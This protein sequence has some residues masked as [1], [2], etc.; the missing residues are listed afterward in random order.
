MIDLGFTNASSTGEKTVFLPQTGALVLETGKFSQ[1]FFS[2][3]GNNN[4]KVENDSLQQAISRTY[5]YL[6]QDPTTSTEDWFPENQALRFIIDGLDN[7]SRQAYLQNIRDYAES[8][9]IDPDLVIACFLGEQ[10][11]IAQ[12]STRET[13]KET[14]LSATPTLFRS[15]NVSLGIG[16]IKLS[17][18]QRIQRDAKAYDSPIYSSVELREEN[19]ADDDMLNARYATQL[20]RNILHR[21]QLSGY[22]LTPPEYAG[23]VCTLYNMGNHPK[24]E[25]H[26]D[27]QI[28]GSIISI[29]GYDY[30]YGGLSQGVY[31]YLKRDKSE[32]SSKFDLTFGER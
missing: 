24:K 17:T 1:N 7:P 15:H 8:L 6:H 31:F 32:F 30:T 14:L 18:A 25:P 5:D 11:R 19:L 9:E 20:V 12:Q 27:P 29:N 28:G 13:V 2:I 3:S 23:I 4:G 22:D 21:W 26:S 10:I 16:G